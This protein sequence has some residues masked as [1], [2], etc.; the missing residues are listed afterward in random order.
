MKAVL[1]VFLLLFLNAAAVAQDVKTNDKVSTTQMDVVLATGLPVFI[2]LEKV[3]TETQ[4][5]IARLYRYQN[6][7]V[8]K[9]LS[10]KTKKDRPKL[11]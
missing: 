3:G 1:T 8:K 6:S 5:S 7:R 2:S 11:A 4:N 10:F 9:A